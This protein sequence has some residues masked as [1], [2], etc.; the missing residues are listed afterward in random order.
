MPLVRATLPTPLVRAMPRTPL[1]RAMPP[2]SLARAI[3]LVQAMLPT[4]LARAMLLT[5]PMVPAPLRASVGPPG[6]ENSAS[7]TEFIPPGLVVYFAE[8]LLER[9]IAPPPARAL[10][11][12][13]ACGACLPLHYL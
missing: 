6:N 7:V 2:T 4:P 12:V 1:V 5:L 3:L 10:L 9:V 13:C 11:V 8:Y